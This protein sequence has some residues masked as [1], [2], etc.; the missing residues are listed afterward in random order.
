M[1]DIKSE[2]KYQA[3][4]LTQPI[5]H[6]LYQETY[7]KARDILVVGDALNVKQHIDFFSRFKK[8]KDE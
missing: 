6:E 1:D 2:V 8:K 3:D 4:S 5:R 7:D